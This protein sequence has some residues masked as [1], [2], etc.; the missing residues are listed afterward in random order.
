MT[1]VPFW[2]NARSEHRRSAM[3]LA[4]LRYDDPRRDDEGPAL[5]DESFEQGWRSWLGEGGPDVDETGRGLYSPSALDGM[6]SPAIPSPRGLVSRW[7]DE[8][9]RAMSGHAPSGLRI[10]DGAPGGSLKETRPMTQGIM[11]APADPDPFAA[12]PRG[13]RRVPVAGKPPASGKESDALRHSSS[14]AACGEPPAPEKRA[15][16][17]DLDLA[18]VRLV[19]RRLAP[20]DDASQQDARPGERRDHGSDPAVPAGE[21]RNEP[22]PEA[23]RADAEAQEHGPEEE[24]TEAHHLLGVL[25]DALE[26]NNAEAWEEEALVWR[27]LF[28]PSEDWAEGARRLLRG[29]VPAEPP[30]SGPADFAVRPLT[31]AVVSSGGADR[32][33]A[34]GSIGEPEA[35]AAGLLS[36]PEGRL[37]PGAL[38][39]AD[40]DRPAPAETAVRETSFAE[41]LMALPAPA[42]TRRVAEDDDEE[43]EEEDG[44]D[45]PRQSTYRF[46]PAEKREE[47]VEEA[48]VKVRIQMT[49]YFAGDYLAGN[50]DNY[51]VRGVSGS[52]AMAALAP[53]KEACEARFPR[54]R[55]TA[56]CRVQLTE[57]TGK[58]SAYMR[59]KRGAV[60]AL[61]MNLRGVTAEE[62][63]PLVD[64]LLASRFGVRRRGLGALAA[65]WRRFTEGGSP[66]PGGGCLQ[67]APPSSDSIVAENRPNAVQPD[68]FSAPVAPADSISAPESKTENAGNTVQ[69]NDSGK[70]PDP[71][72]AQ[73]LALC[74]EL[75]EAGYGRLS[76]SLANAGGMVKRELFADGMA[77]IV[78]QGD[79][80]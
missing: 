80:P 28:E 39:F 70:L 68:G 67:E 8:E 65:V 4:D 57:Q 46:V 59:R 32:A 71:T 7:P 42:A 24:M 6:A 14:R 58:G 47:A 2:T 5:S 74:A 20:L 73:V 40:L 36:D 37:L 45:A 75:R 22:A 29:R 25:L 64:Y 77:M 69:P 30:V 78:S 60:S 52:E 63:S 35:P 10:R 26:Q 43:G 9:L 34:H 49:S 19:L 41:R 33:E 66:K 56:R 27:D 61:N 51:M 13:T 55:G 11:A 62:A 53:L 44:G 54:K 1:T 72:R 79:R 76:D 23:L 17:R 21:A 16:R 50:T 3:V 31:A 48:G 38:E 15:L 12:L 18:A